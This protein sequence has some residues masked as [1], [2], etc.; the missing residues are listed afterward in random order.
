M[1]ASTPASSSGTASADDPAHDLDLIVMGAGPAGAAAARV[2]AAAGLSVALVDKA[3]FPRDKL[4]GGGVT[5]RSALYF[6]EIYGED[7]PAHLIDTKTSVE[8]HA[9]GHSLG[10]LPDIPPMHLAMRVELDAEMQRRAIRA[11]AMDLSGCRVAALDLAPPALSLADGRRLRAKVLIGADGVNSIVARQLFGQSYDRDQIGFGLEVEAAPGP[12]N[13]AAPLRID[14]G[15]ADWGYGWHFPK[16]GSSTIGIGGVLSRNA[17]MKASMA[18]YL[19]QL[20]RDPSL[21]CKGHH[22]PFGEVHKRPGHGAVLLAG[23][24]AGLVDPITGEGIAYAM[25]SGQLAALAA[26]EAIAAGAPASA[27]R[28]YRRRLVPVHRAMRQAR[29]IRV[30][31]FSPLFRPAF[32]AAFRSSG[33]LRHLY[34]RLLAGEIEYGDMMRATLRRLPS[35]LLGAARNRGDTT[36]PDQGA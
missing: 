30:L 3:R 32:V 8:F 19:A 13:A 7:I 36:Q 11:G 21:P 23:D 18:A 16:R 24:A 31:I 28:R 9:F 2:A 1:P 33:R 20:G 12:D 15:A 27:L 14:F 26:A 10:L 29:A 4:C 25:K 5:G 22:L 34:M 17:D 35:F 6:R